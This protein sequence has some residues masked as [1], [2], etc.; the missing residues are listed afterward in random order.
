MVNP[1][2]VAPPYPAR[3]AHSAFLAAHRLRR[4]RAC[5]RKPSDDFKVQHIRL[6]VGL[7]LRL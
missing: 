7:R 4:E 1:Q 5:R 6:D 3:A 2:A